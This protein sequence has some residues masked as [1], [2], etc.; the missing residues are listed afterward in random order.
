[1][2]LETARLLEAEIW[3]QGFAAPLF[4]DVFQ[5]DKQRLLKERHLKLQLS[6]PGA[7]FDAIQFN[8]ADT[9]PGQIRA[10]YRLS[11]NEYQGVANVQL[12]LE[13]FEPA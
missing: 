4:E 9:V 2:S 7:V 5:V 1:M 6:K 13:Y 3:G 8:C 11:V 12:M 10:A